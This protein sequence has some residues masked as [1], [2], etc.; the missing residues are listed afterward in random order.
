MTTYLSAI[1][2]GLL[3]TV[4]L[5]ATACST[6]PA[7]IDTSP[8]AEVTFDGLHKVIHSKADEAWARPD[9]DLSGYTKIMPV[10]AEVNYKTATNKGQSQADRTRGGTFVIDAASRHQFEALVAEVFLGEM[11]KST[12]YTLV[13]EPG[14]DVLLVS[15]SLIDVSSFVPPTPDGVGSGVAIRSVGEATLV[16]ELRDSETGTALAR[17][18]DRRSADM[19]GRQLQQSNSV[20]NKVEVTNM[21]TFWAKRLREQL[22]EF[23]IQAS[24]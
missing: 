7:T 9:I 1:R 17:S 24:E 4:S 10:R 14:P 21:L 3:I 18:V 20:V 22:D 2:L 19:Y 6:G 23:D 11:A 15:V 5:F 13:D 16:L 12:R 8:T